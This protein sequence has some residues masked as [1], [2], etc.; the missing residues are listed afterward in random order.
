[1]DHLFSPW[2]YR[3]LAE[4]RP[5][6][7]GCVLCQELAAADEA[8]SLV[9]W[10]GRRCAIMLNRLPYTSG[11]VMILPLAHCASLAGCGTETTSEMMALATRAETVLEREYRAQGLNIGLNLGAAA[12]AGI[13]GHLHLHVVP[14][15]TGDANFMSVVGETRVLP[16]TLADTYERL[17]RG[18]A[19]T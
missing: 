19:A 5:E 13:A 3:Y 8:A 18:F 12:G 11:H 10:R 14:R 17:R 16:E 15:W 1:M 7:D 9:V 2:R 4:A 6:G